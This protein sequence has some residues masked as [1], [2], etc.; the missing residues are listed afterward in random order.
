[1]TSGGWVGDGSWRMPSDSAGAG[2][3][4]RQA[5]CARSLRAAH[6]DHL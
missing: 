2:R 3:R 4:T 6:R 5:R 1:M